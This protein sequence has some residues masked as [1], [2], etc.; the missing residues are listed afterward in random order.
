MIEMEMRGIYFQR[1]QYTWK[2]VFKNEKKFGLSAGSRWE[3]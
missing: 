1:D 3:V 2:A